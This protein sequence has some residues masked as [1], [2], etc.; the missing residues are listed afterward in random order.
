M[1]AI[2]FSKMLSDKNFTNLRKMQYKYPDKFNEFLSLLNASFY[3]KLPL[4][5]FKGNN[6]VYLNNCTNI[7]LQA[8]KL[9]YSY[10][11]S[12]FGNKA[13]EEE[14]LATSKI[15]NIDFNRESVRNIMKGHAPKDEEENRIYG[16][17]KGYEF[18]S[19]VTNKINEDNIYKLYSIAIGNFLDAENILKANNHYRHDYVYIVGTK[20]EH[21]GL[22]PKKISSY[23]NDLI[24]FINSDDNINDLLKASMIHFYF[25]YIHP[26]FDGNG[27]MSRLM[28]MWY[29]IQKGYK[30]TMFIS[31]SSYIE[32]TRKKYYDAYSLCEDNYKILG[33]LDVTPFLLYTIENIYDKFDETSL[34]SHT[35]ELYDEALK[36]G[37]ITIKEKELWKFVLS[38]YGENTFTTKQL[39]KDYRDVAYATV[40]NFVLKF[41]KLGLLSSTKL[42]NKTLY[43][44]K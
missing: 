40:Y 25:S 31:F 14:I 43:K 9:L 20:V 36:D 17:K 15:E 18:I 26:Y 39:E 38:S 13:I 1:E 21:V 22:D 24:N 32:K 23:M 41:S 10:K 34:N 5:D 44:I 8:V 29:L 35:L 7:N 2:E 16:L 42:A 37:E 11:D 30:S 19:D 6:I 27:R 4:K 28:H 3:N 12:S 33:K